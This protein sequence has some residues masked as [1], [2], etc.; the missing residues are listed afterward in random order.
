MLSTHSGDHLD[1]LSLSQVALSVPVDIALTATQAIGCGCACLAVCLRQLNTITKI[2]HVYS[3]IL[4]LSCFQSMRWGR[5]L[6][7]ASC[8]THTHTHTH[9]VFLSVTFCSHVPIYIPQRARTHDLRTVRPASPVALHCRSCFHPV[10][11]G[12][13]CCLL[14]K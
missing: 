14:V 7:Y 13:H 5:Y 2:C 1:A 6:A 12:E 3:F 8:R 11:R 10:R 9:N 4:L